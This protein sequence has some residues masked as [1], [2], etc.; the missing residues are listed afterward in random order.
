M[1]EGQN[2]TLLTLLPSLF[3]LHS[4]ANGA[5]S[6]QEEIYRLALGTLRRHLA[7]A[8]VAATV[9]DGELEVSGHRLGLSV[10][11]EGMVQQG[12]HVF[13]PLDIRI[14]LDGDEG[15]KFRVGTLGVGPDREAAS[16]AAV[17]EWHVL[18]A[19]PLLA[20]LGAPLELRRSP[21]QHV[22]WADW[23]VFPGRA[24]I[25]GP[26]PPVMQADGSLLREVLETL[27]DAVAS[28]PAPI[29]WEMRSIFIMATV[30][31]D[32]QE[33]QAAVSG[34]VDEP[35]SAKLA[36]LPWPKPTETFFYKQL[37]VLRGGKD[38]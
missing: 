22:A 15:D 7:E 2:R 28:W 29:R 19:A 4:S 11:C 18:A 1:K 23:S 17:A 27:R 36:A 32:G 25:R 5:F 21:R 34:F 10:A 13:A 38:E 30:G 12:E 26:L 35:L 6:M 24:V 37:F 16:Q 14:H 31:P 33:V 20:A 9:E 3:S 8:G